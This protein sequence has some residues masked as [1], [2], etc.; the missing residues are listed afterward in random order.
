MNKAGGHEQ[1]YDAFF[2]EELALITPEDVRVM[3]HLSL[4]CDI[5]LTT[6]AVLKE[7]P[8]YSLVEGRWTD[9]EKDRIIAKWNPLRWYGVAGKE[10]G[11]LSVSGWDPERVRKVYGDHKAVLMT[12]PA[13]RAEEWRKL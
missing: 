11:R 13:A 8:P 1:D 4:E 7:Y 6:G 3:E 2:V 10:S 9:E 12:D 5:D